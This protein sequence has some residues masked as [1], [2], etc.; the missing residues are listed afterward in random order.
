M[1]NELTNLLPLERQK[2]LS[3]NYFLRL[4]V[5]GAVLLSMLTLIAAL[6]LIPTYLLLVGSARAKEARLTTIESALSPT[7]EATLSAHLAALTNDATVL[8]ALAQAPSMSGIIRDVLAVPH[9]GITLSDFTY[10]PAAK[11]AP[12]TLAVSGTAVT[13]DMLRSYQLA[14]QGAPF[15]R[16]AALPVSAYAKDADIAFTITLTLAP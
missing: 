14:L 3:R 15:A 4:G 9:P 5:I 16:A 2:A 11:N 7:D 8:T 1:R 10:V 6:L 13:R 12:A